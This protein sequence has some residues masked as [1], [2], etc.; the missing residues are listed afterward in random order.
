MKSI[1][2]TMATVVLITSISG[3]AVAGDTKHE[4]PATTTCNNAK[5][6]DSHQEANNPLESDAFMKLDQLQREVQQLEAKDKER[7][8]EEQKSNQER[9]KQ[10]RQ[11]YEEW[12]HSLMGIY[13]G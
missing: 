5:Q 3:F 13:G 12:E 9:M 6:D 8:E 10:L 7:Q 1:M 4:D 2:H 11:Q